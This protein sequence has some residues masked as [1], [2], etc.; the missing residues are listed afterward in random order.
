MKPITFPEHNTILKAPQ[1]MPNCSDLE[2]WQGRNDG[3]D[4]VTISC[5]KPTEQEIEYLKNGG[6]VYLIVN[7]FIFFPTALICF[8]PFQNGASSAES[9]L[10]NESSL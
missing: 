3:G 9:I 5:W 6:E 2:V 4:D 1:E 10:G 8:N 7:G